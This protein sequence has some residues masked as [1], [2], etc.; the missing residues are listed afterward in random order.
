MYQKLE[1][2]GFL[3]IENFLNKKKFSKVQKEVARAVSKADKIKVSAD[4]P[5][6]IDISSIAEIQDICKL[7]Q[8]DNKFLLKHLYLRKVV[9]VKPGEYHEEARQYNYHIDKFYSNYK[10]WFYPFEIKEEEGDSGESWTICSTQEVLP[11]S[12][13]EA[14][15]RAA[16]LSPERRST[17]GHIT[18]YLKLHR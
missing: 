16:T 11:E 18:F 15:P 10:I 13:Q 14:D 9:H 2:N 5:L 3:K 8:A 1:R 12:T 7:C 17:V 4:L 6:L